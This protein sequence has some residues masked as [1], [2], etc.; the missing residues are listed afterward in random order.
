MK[1]SYDELES[2]KSDVEAFAADYPQAAHAAYD[3]LLTIGGA[4]TDT[5]P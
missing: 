2:L 4:M 1:W 5:A 3:L